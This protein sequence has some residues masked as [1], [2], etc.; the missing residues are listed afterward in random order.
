[1][2]I[3][4]GVVMARIYSFD[5]LLSS[6]VLASS[7]IRVGLR[8]RHRYRIKSEPA[9]LRPISLLTSGSSNNTDDSH[10]RDISNTASKPKGFTAASSSLA[11]TR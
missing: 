8:W 11:N 9:V 2:D 7:G 6:I 4:L 3:L 5:S 10:R 1:M